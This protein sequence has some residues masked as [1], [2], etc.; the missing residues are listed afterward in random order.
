MF[1][2][3][4]INV[5]EFM[6][7]L[8]FILLISISFFDY[9]K[10]DTDRS[11]LDVYP[12]IS[13]TKSTE[14]WTKE[15]ILNFE[16]SAAN[17]LESYSFNDGELVKIEGEHYNLI[18]KITKN[19]N[20]ILTI[21]DKEGL[22]TSN[23]IEINNIDDKAPILENISIVYKEMYSLITIESRDD[24]SGLDIEPYSFDSCKTWSSK[25]NYEVTEEKEYTICIKDIV[26]N[27]YSEKINVKIDK[28]N[29][30][31]INNIIFGE[32]IDNNKKITITFLGCH[33]C[34]I[35]IKEANKSVDLS[36]EWYNITNTYTTYLKP[37]NYK[38]WLKDKED[39]IVATKEF[40]V[41]INLKNKSLY[42]TLG[43]ILMI[44][45]ITLLC[46]YKKKKCNKI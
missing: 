13:Y 37:G 20:Y 31:I 43:V 26:G 19:D 39:K 18:K 42:L 1:V 21:K 5:G 6:K 23:Q 27:I 36:D 2:C 29:L 14:K 16:L 44:F 10:A 11:Q 28:A 40:V 4:N 7:K 34:K 46:V 22:E 45:S 17:G 32:I 33:E 41:S 12:K 3:Y 24:E 38:I 8:I 25:N 9:V 30:P 35:I 15:L